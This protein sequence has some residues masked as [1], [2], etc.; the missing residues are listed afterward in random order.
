MISGDEDGS[1]VLLLFLTDQAY[2]EATKTRE[3]LQPFG[4]PKGTSSTT[5]METLEHRKTMRDEKKKD[6]NTTAYTRGGY[7]IYAIHNE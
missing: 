3:R 4:I 5:V 7:K 6:Q 1:S 2:L